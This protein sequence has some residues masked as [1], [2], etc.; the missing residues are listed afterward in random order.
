MSR[1]SGV[2]WEFPVAIESCGKTVL[3]PGITIT[4]PGSSVWE[5]S[6]LADF[7]IRTD[8]VVAVR[9]DDDFESLTGSRFFRKL[10]VCSPAYLTRLTR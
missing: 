3:V 7:S 9:L 8:G 10:R 1:A 5:P 4:G 2:S 6:G